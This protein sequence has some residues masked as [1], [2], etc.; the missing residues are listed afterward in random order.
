MSTIEYR[1]IKW[2]DIVR[3]KSEDLRFL[4]S[5]GFHHLLVSE[6]ETPTYHPLV[7]YYKT[8]LFWI[9]HFPAWDQK[10]EQINSI[11]IDF[12][13]TNDMLIT[14]RYQEFQDFENLWKS[15]QEQRGQY[16]DK[17]TGHLFYHVVKTLLNKTFPELDRI[18]EALDQIETLI[19]EDLDET[20]IEKIIYTDHHILSFLRALK[21]QK[22][23]WDS[24]P[25][26]VQM[27]W[28][29]RLKPY[30]SDLIADYRRTLHVAETHKETINSLHLSSNSLL[31]NKRNHVV[32]ILTIF[33]A[34]ILPLSLFASVYGMNLTHL[35]LASRADAFWWFLGGMAAITAGMLVYFRIKKWL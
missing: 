12:L 27:F 33:T 11:E 18:K 3:P 17:T 19:L 8:Y 26:Y 35:P 22:T 25:Q 23:V 32:K 5:N 20:I 31:D 24:A 14:I 1:N 28:G 4:E 16:L 15:V 13:V 21:P 7:E 9:L 30:F 34:I 6:V 29:D 10:R 2:I